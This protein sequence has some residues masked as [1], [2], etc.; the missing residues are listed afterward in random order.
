MDENSADFQKTLEQFQCQRCNECCKK[1][2]FVYLREGESQAIARFLGL[3]DF[4]FVNRFCELQE[5]RKIVLKKH[6]DESCV[7]LHAAEGC[8]IHAVKPGQCQDF[9]RKWRTPGS[10]DYCAGLKKIFS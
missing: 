10:L 9:P 8:L 1:P 3:S 7:F 5:R 2:G 4:E 6:T